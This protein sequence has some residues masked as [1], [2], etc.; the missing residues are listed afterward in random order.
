M[1]LTAC[2]RYDAIL[3]GFTIKFMSTFSYKSGNSYDT[4]SQKSR[5]YG[6]KLHVLR[7]P[8]QLLEFMVSYMLVLGKALDLFLKYIR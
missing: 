6:A 8:Q 3:R 4:A 1:N 5:S 2:T 7:I